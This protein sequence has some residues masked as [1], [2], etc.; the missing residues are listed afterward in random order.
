MTTDNFNY[1]VDLSSSQSLNKTG[2]WLASQIKMA[3]SD[4][5]LDEWDDEYRMK[6]GMAVMKRN[7]NKK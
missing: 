3:T 1:G 5:L 4:A 7:K 2:E 6:V